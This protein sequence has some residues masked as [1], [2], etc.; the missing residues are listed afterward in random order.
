MRKLSGLQWVIVLLTLAT[1]VIHLYL[2]ASNW[3]SNP[4]MAALWALD[5]V[6]YIVILALL[7]FSGRTGR[8]RS[9]MRWILIFYTLLTL[10]LYFV[11]EGSNAFSNTLGL[12]TKAIEALLIILLFL[13]RG[14]DRVQVPAAATVDSAVAGRTMSEVGGA[15]SSTAAAVTGAAAAA[16]AG[17]AAAASKADTEV[18]ATVDVASRTMDPLTG[19]SREA[20]LDY[21]GDIDSMGVDEWRAKLMGHLTLMGDTSQFDR[22]IEYIEGI[23][24]VLGRKWRA[25]DVTKTVDLLVFGATRKGRVALAKRSG[26]SESE[27]LTWANQVDLYRIL[28]VAKEYADLLE[29]TGVDT[30]VELATRN[31][32]NL[33][34]AMVEINDRRKLVRRTPTLTEVESWVNQAA[35]LPRVIHY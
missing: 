4:T 34:K 6:G 2:G 30:V 14:S 22:P 26:F 27:I 11:F 24:D 35:T 13:D 33:Q 18:D 3:G 8:G 15:T 31:P 19:M 10:I 1:A 29:Q 5:G 25:V 9:T 32:A 17:V 20:L 23:G 16:A 21:F 12:I 7:Y 28:G